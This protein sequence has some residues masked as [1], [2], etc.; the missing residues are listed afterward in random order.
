MTDLTI[1]IVTQDNKQQLKECLDSIYASCKGLS[2]EIFVVDNNSS[3]GT[4]GYISNMHSNVKWIV[5]ERK[6]SFAHNHNSILK[7]AKGEY[8][9]IL[10]DDTVILD[11]A[12]IK[13]ANYL[14]EKPGIG[15][16]GPRMVTKD[17]AYQQSAFR[18]PTLADLFA[19]Y[20]F[21]KITAE[22]K[23]TSLYKSIEHKTKPTEADWLLGACLFF[24]RQTINNIGYLDES[25]SYAYMEDTDFSKRTKNA[26]LKVVYY[27]EAEIIHHGAQTTQKREL[28]MKKILY[29]NRLK[30]FKK[31][32][33]YFYYMLSVFTLFFSSGCNIIFDIARFLCLKINIGC[34]L[35]NLKEYIYIT[36]F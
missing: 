35:K 18:F 22:S 9:V 8:I 7:V 12:F 5:N 19:N 11:S 26:G 29:K 16:M 3:D 34:L 15:L 31:H 33:G 13:M 17:K 2:Y 14:R 21:N 30:F 25:F 23:F 32:N 28:F 20:F 36:G 1:S 24:P 27:P 10:N 4:R 6:E